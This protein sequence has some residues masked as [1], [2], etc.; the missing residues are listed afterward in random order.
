MPGGFEHTL[1]TDTTMECWK[2]LVVSPKTLKNIPNKNVH[3]IQKAE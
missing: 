2:A 1:M 3:N